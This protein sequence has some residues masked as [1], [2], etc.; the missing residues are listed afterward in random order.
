MSARAGF[1]PE[2]INPVRAF[3]GSAEHP[4]LQ[5]VKTPANKRT[6]WQKDV[7]DRYNE[8][9]FTP[10]MSERD[11]IHFSRSWNKAISQK[12]F[13]NLIVPGALRTLRMIS[14][15]FMEH[16]IPAMK[17]DAYMTRT[18][19]AMRRDPSLVND[20]DKRALV[21][22]G[23]AKDLDR[24]YG[25]MNYDTLFWNKKLKDVAKVA[26]ISMG[27]KLAQLYYY[28]GKPVAEIPQLLYKWAKTGRV[29]RQAI[30][31]QS[32][33]MPAYWMVGTMMGAMLCYALSG[34]PPHSYMD[35]QFPPTGEK[36]SDGSP[37]RIA[38]PFFNKEAHSLRYH[39]DQNGPLKGVASFLGDMS[40]IPNM[41][42]FANNEDHFGNPL[43]SEWNWEQVSHMALYEMRPISKTLY[44][45]AIQ[46]KDKT[47]A[48]LAFFGAG[49]APSY[50][51][52]TPFENK[53]TATYYREH[54][55]H[56]S[57]YQTDLKNE[58][59]QAVVENDQAK[60]QELRQKMADTGMNPKSIASLTRG[61]KDP[62]YRWKE[63]TA[64]SQIELYGRANDDE[65]KKYFPMMKPDAKRQVKP[66]Q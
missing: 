28:M 62:N 24:T 5:A 63:L 19:L 42:S 12:K 21:F 18:T 61:I 30:S 46:N 56:G 40:P 27:W 47:A 50:V 25:E 3:K 34:Q 23:I 4:L 31:Y 10:L 36:A 58:Y 64:E 37:V 1:G 53:V 43:I 22:R 8:G 66:P 38:L 9:G 26:F 15:P 32:L 60:A 57:V 33:M 49:V 44:D 11:Q 6:P 45:K 29:D 2:G 7:V 59:K 54:G 13:Q 65:K 39:V 17:A 20:A 41:W 55:S 16:W 14:S 52:K 48:K 35:T 51:G